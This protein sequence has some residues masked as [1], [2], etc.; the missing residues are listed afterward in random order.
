[1]EPYK[2]GG[3]PWTS[4]PTNTQQ[5]LR[6]SMPDST[7]GQVVRITV[8][9]VSRVAGEEVWFFTPRFLRDRNTAGNMV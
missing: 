9:T 1:M 4:T 5:R 8:F 2:Q 7:Q 6:K 3:S